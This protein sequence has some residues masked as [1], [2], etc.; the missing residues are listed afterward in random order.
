[1]VIAYD[2]L[3]HSEHRLGRDQGAKTRP[4][5][6]VIAVEQDAS[7]RLV[8]VVPVTHAPPSEAENAVEIPPA[9]KRRLGLDDARSW[10]VVTE[11][12]RFSWPGPDIRPVA[13]GRFAY[14]LLPP[15]LF[16]QVRLKLRAYVAGK[17]LRVT[18]RSD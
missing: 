10:V 1:L 18:S 13:P 8:T 12:N 16:D 11:V 6:I 2:F 7:R 9:T 4:C 14:G 15:A 5:V 3:W 17:R